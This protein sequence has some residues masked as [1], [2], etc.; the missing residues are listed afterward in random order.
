[1]IGKTISHYR[2]LE[3]L[4]GGGMG[5]VYEAEDLALGRHV[6]MKFLPERLAGHPLALERFRREA[7]AASAINHPNICTIHEIG[8][9][10]GQL[11][12]VM[13]L[14]SGQTLKHLIAGKPLPADRILDLGVQI[15]DAL[16]AAHQQGIV[17][18]DIKPANI[19][20]TQRGQA[21]IL[22]FG[23]AKLNGPE[24]PDRGAGLAISPDDGSEPVGQDSPTAS[25]DL[26]HLTRPGRTMGTVAYMSPEQARGEELDH[27]T[28]LFSFGGV[29][30]EMA[31]GIQPFGGAS[32]AVIFT[33][34]LRDEPEKPTKAAP[35]LPADL[36]KIIG[37][38]LEKDLG[39]RYQSAAEVENDLRRL[40]QQLELGLTSKGVTATTAPAKAGSES[41]P[42]GGAT[43]TR[44]WLA[45]GL[46][47]LGVTVA[48]YLY[49]RTHRAPKLT[50]KDTVV[51]ADFMNQ[52][53][54]PVFDDTLKQA[55][56]V[57]LR[58]SPF[59]NVLSDSQVAATLRLMERSAGTP[60]SGDVAREVCQRAGARAY[61]AGSIA[62]LGSQY[63]LGLKA[64]GCGDGEILA[65][66]Q[67]T[68]GGK[69]K[70]LDALGQAAAKLRRELGES[71]A[72]VKKFDTPLDQAT[73]TSLEALKALS[74]A[75]KAQLNQ[76]S[77]AALPFFRQA[78]E[79]DPGFATAYAGLGLMYANMGQTAHAGEFMAKAF[80]LRN[81]SSEPERLR[82][83]A[84]Y[85]NYVTG[86][87]ARADQTYEEWLQEYPR[88]FAAY[89]D[90]AV[91]RLQEGEYGAAADLL[92]HALLLR[93]SDVIA[94]AD[95]G[96]ALMEL[97]RTDGARKVA[98]EA[99]SH[100]L[101]S[102][103][104][105]SV[106]YGLDFL[107]GNTE[108]MAEQASWF[109]RQPDVQNEI[110]SFESDTEA[111]SG[112]ISKAREFTRRA[113]DSAVH[114][115]NPEAAAAWRVNSALREAAFGNTAQARAETEAALRLAPDSKDIKAQAALAEAW[116]GDDRAAETLMRDLERQ[117]PLDTLVND[118]W[119]PTIQARI[120][121][122]RKNPAGALG[123]LQ[124]L[125]SP[126]E[127]GE[128]VISVLGV[129]PY[130]VYT[131]GEAYLAAGQGDAAVAEFQ[132]IL[133]RRGLVVNCSLGA[134]AQL[135]LARAYAI[136]IR[137]ASP[138]GEDLRV[139]ARG[140]Y[141]DFLTLWKDADPGIPVLKEAKKEYA[142]LE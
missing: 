70:A 9:Q 95:L 38:A 37:K 63:V 12:I 26:D 128:P 35:G 133:D 1:M 71:L 75:A 140:A 84:F 16:E 24:S 66:D 40:K 62:R 34:I 64:V 55:L 127:L 8:E 17:H 100:Q 51:L 123:Q 82:I 130:P 105:R 45:A 13:E 103:G 56:A 91:D 106:L 74:L 119:L 87:L 93:P 136:E 25:I 58:Q 23:L 109:D 69:E 18:R 14:L 116:I 107:A 67:T 41:V 65:E 48:G 15:A 108:G 142:Q 141:Q 98:E 47:A 33:A 73:T 134:L 121:L 125:S 78:I 101:D 61:I 102:D 129:C 115:A 117:F 7:R 32:T 49:W 6:A 3:K 88:D 39:R 110:L 11:F 53:G 99:R 76:G 44:T 80:A 104:L 83:T 28:D 52:T 131:R 68:A 135:G 60:V 42:E 30:Y 77:S 120:K 112:H 4:G 27:R 2:I 138:R 85:Y 79:L 81:R 89:A 72:S 29:L 118:Y 31:T 10:D 96:G 20:V 86:E 122:A 46:V 43:R 5:L 113:V 111:Y 137:A 22:D 21:K 36:E 92:R 139:R 132:R 19:F 124:T 59:L 94:Y 126:L 114:A 97:G 54:D 57:A 50:E 90:L